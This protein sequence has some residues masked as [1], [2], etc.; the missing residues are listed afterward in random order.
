[1]TKEVLKEEE[2]FKSGQAFTIASIRMTRNRNGY[3]IEK[4]SFH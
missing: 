4:A 2:L 1:M 3:G